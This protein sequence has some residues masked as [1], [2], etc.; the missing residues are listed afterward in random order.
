MFYIYL[1]Q[2]NI[3]KSVNFSHAVI[4]FDD[5]LIAQAFIENHCRVTNA[6]TYNRIRRTNFG[7]TSPR[8]FHINIALVNGH[9]FNFFHENTIQ[10]VRNAVRDCSN[11]GLFIHSRFKI[12]NTSRSRD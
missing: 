11:K 3:N 7:T 12:K 2:I 4:L 6:N 5:L 8:Y 10:M 1:S 9:R